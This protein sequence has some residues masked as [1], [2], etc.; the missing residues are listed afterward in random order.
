MSK[1]CLVVNDMIELLT[2][3]KIT[4]ENRMRL[5]QIN[6]HLMLCDDCKDQYKKI[7]AL[8]DIVE[9]WSIYEQYS[10]EKQLQY[11]K[12]CLSLLRAKN[13]AIPSI[14]ARIDA[15]L[16]NY[17][18]SSAKIIVDISDSIKLAVDRAS[19]FISDTMFIEFGHAHAATSRSLTFGETVPVDPCLLIDE[20]NSV[21]QVKIDNHR[22][23]KISLEDVNGIAPLIA[24]IPHDSNASATVVEPSY[25]TASKC[26]ITE[27]SN[28][29]DGEYDVIIEAYEDI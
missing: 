20:N 18:A 17:A 22:V 1:N 9:G 2:S 27:I 25:C 4:P 26:W 14:A 19:M 16:K 15:W 5:I 21:N 10:T 23:L 7:T 24:I 28:L 13:A 8:Y 11:M 6:N 3:E 29:S 12:G